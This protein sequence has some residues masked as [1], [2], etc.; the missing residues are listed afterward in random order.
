MNEFKPKCVY[1]TDG[2]RKRIRTKISLYDGVPHG[3]W[4]ISRKTLEHNAAIYRNKYGEIEPKFSTYH[5]SGVSP[6]IELNQERYMVLSQL[7]AVKPDLFVLDANEVVGGIYNKL[8][9][10]NFLEFGSKHS[11]SGAN[12][13]APII[14][15]TQLDVTE[16]ADGVYRLEFA[17]IICHSF[18]N[19]NQTAMGTQ[20]RDNC[21][22]NS[23]LKQMY[24][25]VI[26]PVIIPMLSPEIKSYLEL[27]NYM[28]Q[29]EKLCEI[30]D[31]VFNAQSL[32][33][34]PT[35]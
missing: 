33:K 2:E 13:G 23:L 29:S 20:G 17:D 28:E 27:G 22:D 15:K 35:V 31:E 24:D 9:E 6:C 19:K 12:N 10:S 32:K 25:E 11:I 4:L 34:E 26:N 16:D 5:I 21:Y 14:A 3:E 8:R 1:F 18:Y 7:K 30:N